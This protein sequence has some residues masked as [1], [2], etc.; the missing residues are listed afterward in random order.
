MDDMAA[1]I[2]E[3]MDAAA[4]SRT[5]TVQDNALERTSDA[6]ARDRAIRAVVTAVGRRSARVRSAHC[7]QKQHGKRNRGAEE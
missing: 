3:R 2:C 4:L 5:G 6:Y 7:L 1:M